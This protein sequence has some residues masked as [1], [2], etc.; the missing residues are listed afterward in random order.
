MS[1]S[2]RLRGLARALA[3]A[4]LAVGQGACSTHAIREKL[5]P[6][7]YGPLGT[8][9]P[10]QAEEGSIWP[11]RAPSGSFL[12]FDQKA[13]GIGDLVTVIVDESVSAEGS[14]STDL[15]RDSSVSAGVASDVGFAGMIS[16]SVRSVLEVLGV[17]NPGRDVA[18]GANVNV[19]QSNHQNDFEG[20]GTTRREGRFHAIVTCRVVNVLPGGI[21][22]IRGRR[23]LLVNEEEQFLTVEGLVRKEDIT[24]N[25]TVLSASLAEAR[26]GLDGFGVIGEKQR[27]GW[28]AR[29]LDWIF[30]L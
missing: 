30:P 12:F 1:A 15:G 19:A 7:Y 11:G 8:P 17:S 14:A 25:N 29:M 21:F 4:A 26:L 24:I 3:L 23:S 6:P 13:R 22:H 9:A 18:E 27:P 16:Q 5:T 10:Q 28:L 20:D 2:D